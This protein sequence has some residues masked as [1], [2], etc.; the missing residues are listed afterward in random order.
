M[1]LEFDTR[2]RLELV[3]SKI[4][5]DAGLTRPEVYEHLGDHDFRY[6]IRL[7]ANAALRRETEFH[8][9]RPERLEPGQPVVT[10]RDFAYRDGSAVTPATNLAGENRAHRPSRWAATRPVF[11]FRSRLCRFPEP[12]WQSTA[13]DGWRLNQRLG[14]PVGYGESRITMT[15]ME[16]LGTTE[17][18]M[19]APHTKLE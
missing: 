16:R 8:L 3:G 11:G 4:T 18:E 1:S 2:V 10:Y 14:H 19:R 6:A 17:E 9:A 15:L 12:G 5:S 13:T 7:P